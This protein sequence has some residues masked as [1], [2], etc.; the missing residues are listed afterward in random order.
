MTTRP[1]RTPGRTKKMG[2]VD[3]DRRTSGKYLHSAAGLRKTSVP[4]ARQTY[5]ERI[6]LE[7]V[8]ICARTHTAA[9]TEGHVQRQQLRLRWKFT[10]VSFGIFREKRLN[11][12]PSAG[13]T[14]DPRAVCE[15]RKSLEHGC[16]CLSR[17]LALGAPNPPRNSQ[18]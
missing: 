5:S 18:S 4:P 15:R 8:Y 6:S 9:H 1:K 13:E 10:R 7:R 2:M 16:L 14:R 3:R 17:P 11:L 12:F